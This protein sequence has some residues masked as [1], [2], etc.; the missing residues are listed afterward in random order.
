MMVENGGKKK[1]GNNLLKQRA[2]VIVV[3]SRVAM[4]RDLRRSN[5]YDLHKR[6]PVT[7]DKVVW[8]T[9]SDRVTRDGLSLWFWRI[10]KFFFFLH[11]SALHVRRQ[12][13][14]RRGTETQHDRVHDHHWTSI[15]PRLTINR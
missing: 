6:Q 15:G 1:I 13:F 8:V 10:Y 11:L 2:Q 12:V 3:C 9:L 7:T 4:K 5:C 14:L